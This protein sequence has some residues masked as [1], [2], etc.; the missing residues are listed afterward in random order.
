M[1]LDEIRKKIDLVDEEILQ[2]LAERMRLVREAKKLKTKLGMPV[3]DRNREKEQI[4]NLTQVGKAL[5]LSKSL[6]LRLFDLI[7]RESKRV[8]QKC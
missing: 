7:I 6:V 3:V 2:N 1:K 8:Q 5:K 4:R